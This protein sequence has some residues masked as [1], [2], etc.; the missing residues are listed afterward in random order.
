[1]PSA[2][3]ADLN[4]FVDVRCGVVVANVVAAE[5][6]RRLPLVPIVKSLTATT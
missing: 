2:V 5:G 1:M 3:G 6:C 4:E